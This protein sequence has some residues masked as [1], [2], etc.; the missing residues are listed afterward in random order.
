MAGR[1]EGRS[2]VVTGATKG[3][4]RETALLMAAEG[5]RVVA[6]GRDPHDG[7]SL[8]AEA[9]AL[10]GKVVFHAGDVREEATHVDAVERCR[11][12]G[13]RLDAYV[14][15]A[16]ILGPEGPLHETSLEAWEEVNAVNMRGVF[17]GCRAA[18][19]A[20]RGAGGGSIVNVGSILSLTADPFLSA[21]TA[22]KHG[23]LGLT[24][25]IAVDY[26][27]DGI[28]CNCV[29]PGDM[30]TPMILAYFAASEDPEAARAEMEGSYPIKRIARPR[31]VAMA[32]L[33]LASEESSFVSGAEL[34][35]DGALTAKAY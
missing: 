4:G 28:R 33:F 15:N 12:G 17:L 21:Y 18:L 27:A 26:A 20:M 13:R 35:V 9:A 5:A 11:E 1:L 32:I 2:C 10:P 16:G 14:N 30:E 8:E 29:L 34:L 24:R 22:T 7:R 6:V 23:V 25:A 3:L 19:R 31:E